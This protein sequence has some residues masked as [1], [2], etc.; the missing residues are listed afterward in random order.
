MCADEAGRLEEEGSAGEV[1]SF[2]AGCSRASARVCPLSATRAVS[3]PN[4][5]EVANEMVGDWKAS[6]LL[7]KE[8]AR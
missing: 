1:K 3:Q 6:A 8:E 7:E 2:K 5:S 4:Y